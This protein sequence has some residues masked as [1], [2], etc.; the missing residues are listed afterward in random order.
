ML[1]LQKELTGNKN[2]LKT[3]WAFLNVKIAVVLK[4]TTSNFRQEGLMSQ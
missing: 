4:Q 2:K 3:R 1:W